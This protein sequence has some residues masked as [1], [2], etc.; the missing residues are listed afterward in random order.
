[1][2]EVIFGRGVS[3]LSMQIINVN[4]C[5]SAIPPLATPPRPA[6]RAGHTC[7]TLIYA[8]PLRLRGR[9]ARAQVIV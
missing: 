5:V 7:G 2:G 4:P 9:V 8:A 6:L 1:M 3:V